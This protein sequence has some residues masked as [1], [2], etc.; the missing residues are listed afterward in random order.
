[1]II[2]RKTSNSHRVQKPQ[3]LNI[4]RGRRTKVSRRRSHRF[5][6]LRCAFNRC[7]RDDQHLKIDAVSIFTIPHCCATR[8]IGKLFP[9]ALA[10]VLVIENGLI[11]L[12]AKHKRFGVWLSLTKF[13]SI[14]FDWHN[15][16]ARQYCAVWL[17]EMVV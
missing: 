8:T 3:K 11:F 1:M 10:R 2:S 17:P 16:H 13:K 5:C 4:V 7:V 9:I 12:R 14:S 15:T 6:G